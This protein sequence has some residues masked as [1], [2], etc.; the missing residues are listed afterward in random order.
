MNRALELGQRGEALAWNFLRKQGY[1]ILEKNYRTRFGE[2]DLV[3]EKEGVI[4]FLEVKTRRDHR[5][6]APEE[7]VEWRKRQKLVRVAQ[8]FLQT[9]GLEEKEVRF[10]ILSVT[11]N[12]VDEPRFSLFQDAFIAEEGP[13]TS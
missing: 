10:D 11:W 1:T 13:T 6:G 2:I 12:G 3:A 5:F 8:A 9:K 4:V 7:A